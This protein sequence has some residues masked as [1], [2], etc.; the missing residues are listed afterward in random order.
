MR[1][2][3]LA[4]ML[5]EAIRL[6]RLTVAAGTSRRSLQSDVVD[7][8][9]DM[10]HRHYR[11]I[12]PPQFSDDSVPRKPVM[13]LFHFVGH[14][15]LAGEYRCVCHDETWWEG[16]LVTQGAPA[17]CSCS[18]TSVLVV[19]CMASVRPSAPRTRTNFLSTTLCRSGPVSCWRRRQRD[20]LH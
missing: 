4:P 2:Q 7:R 19:E 3:S 12:H 9:L 18:S 16:R 8:A 20:K 11:W 6:R 10:R 5:L 15:H 14:Q 1:A 13:A 17:A